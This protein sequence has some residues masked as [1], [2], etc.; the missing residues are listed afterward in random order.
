[1]STEGQMDLSPET[2]VAE[3]KPWLEEQGYEVPNDRV[4][5]VHW[6]SQEVMDCPAMKDKLLPWVRNG[7]VQAIGVI[8]DDRLAGTPGSKMIILDTCQQHGV[9]VLSKHSPIPEG[10][11]GELVAYLN[12][13]NKRNTVTEL[14]IRVKDGLRD[15]AK[16]MGLPTN[17][18]TPL[19]FSF[20]Y[21]LRDGR[22]TP[23]AL[24]PNDSTYPIASQIWRMA[25]DGTPLRRICRNLVE[26]GIPAPRGGVA[27][28]TNTIHKIL[29]NPI[30]AGRYY[31]LRQET[32]KP[33]KRQ[34]PGQTY[35]NSSVR[36]R[37]PEDWH[38]L[39]DFPVIAPIVTWPEYE[40]VQERLKRNKLM[41]KR[42]A[43]RFYMLR[44]LLF[45]AEDGRRLGGYGGARGDYYYV[46]SR[47]YRKDQGI[48]PCDGPHLY[49]PT[50]ES[51]VWEAVSALLRDPR[52]FMA[53]ME[54]R[55]GATMTGEVEVQDY[56]ET[57]GRKVRSVDAMETELAGLK[58]RGQ[59]SDVAFERQGALLRAERVHYQ[60]EIERQQAHLATLAQSATAIDNLEVLRCRIV[61]RL[62]SATPEDRRWVLEALDARVTVW[63]G[64]LEVS[65]GVPP[66][67]AGVTGAASVHQG[68]I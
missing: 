49:G 39:E 56:I 11:V 44:G 27:W 65:V 57:L 67:L 7:E 36:A 50:V 6:T 37:A 63:T 47:R 5:K 25:L 15:R 53:E 68:Q 41:S 13:V 4:L 58:L 64:K 14:R 28:G 22:K 52:T 17:G 59:V 20:R 21:A 42:T 26:Q 10:W 43:K 29:R 30:Y 2:Q 46:C 40:A 55:R 3:V 32:T 61:D 16:L 48:E 31:A 45:C 60:D 18:K 12:A 66:H 1:M 9:K 19:G 34:K 54:R 62:E 8:H 33:K 24:E 35:G 51:S 38:L 23:V